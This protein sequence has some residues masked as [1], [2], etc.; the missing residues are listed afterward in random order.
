[1]N[2]ADSG[3]AIHSSLLL[4]IWLA[5]WIP[6]DYALRASLPVNR[7]A[8]HGSRITKNSIVPVKHFLDTRLPA[9]A[10]TY[11]ISTNAVH[12]LGLLLAGDLA[13]SVPNT[14]ENRGRV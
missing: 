10:Q 2:S 4:R 7:G 11:A 12:A 14:A 6:P 1:M 3:I 13:I 9:F 8:L 5:V